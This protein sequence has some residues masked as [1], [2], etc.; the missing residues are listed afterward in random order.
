MPIK[1]PDLS[2]EE[3]SQEINLRE[4]LGE[5][6]GITSVSEAFSQAV[7]DHIVERTESGRDVHGKLFEAYSKSYRKSL[8]FKVFGKSEQVNMKLT[9]DMLGTM[10]TVVENGKLKIKLDGVEN[11]IK[12]YGHMTGY[13]GHP[14]L[15]GKAKRE[16]FGVTEEELN[17]IKKDFVPDFSKEAKK[18]DQSLINSLF[19]AYASFKASGT[20]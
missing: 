4:T 18:N 20:K 15:A 9:G 17:K 14:Y 19:K 11:N 8:A 5:S 13:K 12:A 7:L 10:F 16:F 2:K 6:A 1:K 3:V